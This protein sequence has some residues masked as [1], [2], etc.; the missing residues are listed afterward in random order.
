MSAIRGHIPSVLYVLCPQLH[1]TPYP[2]WFRNSDSDVQKHRLNSGPM[3]MDERLLHHHNRL[4]LLTSGSGR[5]NESAYLVIDLEGA[6]A[7][8]YTTITQGRESCK[9]TV[10]CART[11]SAVRYVPRLAS[12]PRDV[13]RGA[14]A[15]LH[16]FYGKSPGNK[17]PP[18][19]ENE[20]TNCEELCTLLH[21]L[22][23]PGA[24]NYGTSL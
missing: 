15:M 13:K 10:L 7:C 1:P 11:T 14:A 5:F 20:T 18:R 4:R 23:I 2:T 12:P 8:Q 3:H 9:S 6:V 17:T 16:Q 21:L 22:R 24:S 19:R